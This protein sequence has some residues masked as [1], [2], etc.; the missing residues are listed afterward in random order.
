MSELNTAINKGLI[1]AGAG[2]VSLPEE[3]YNLGG[4][5][6]QF[7]GKNFG[8][9]SYGTPKM[10]GEK[11]LRLGNLFIGQYSPDYQY[12]R[13]D[14]PFF[15]SYQEAIEGAKNI[16]AP[17]FKDMRNYQAGD[18]IADLPSVLD[19]DLSGLSKV[20]EK[21]VEM[22]TGGALFTGFRKV[23]TFLA[24]GSSATGQALESSGV[25][26]EGNGWKIGLA[27]DIIGNVGFGAIKP[28]DAQRLKNILID[29]EKNGQTEQ[30]KQL[31]KF[32]KDNG[33]NITVPEAVSSVTGNKSILQLADNVVA[34]EGGAAVISNFTK[35]RFPQITEANRKWMNENFSFLNVDDIDPKII[36]N[37]FVNSLVEAQDNITKKINEKARNLKAGG[38][39]EFDLSNANI[40][41]TTQYM[42]NLFKRLTTGDLLDA[43]IIK[44]NILN[45][46]QSA[47][48]TDLSITNLKKIYDE[49]KDVTRN[50][51][52]E[53]SNQEA[54][55]L[56]KEL[57][58]IKQILDQNEYFARASEFTKRANTVLQGKFDALSIG[59]QVTKSNQ[60]AL[61]RS[62]N[63]IRSVL[64]DENVT[65]KNI[66]NLYTELNKIDATLFPEVSGM[67]LQK[68]FMKIATKGDDPNIGFKFYN[69]MM[70]P[71]NVSL[72]EEII[73]GSAIAQ[74]KD[75][76]KVWQGFTQLMNV[77]K[78]TGSAAKP[79]SQTASRQEFKENLKRLNIPLE[80]FEVTKP[81]S[82]VEGIKN[83]LY[84]QRATELANAFVSDDG[85]ESLIKIANASSFDQIV[86]NNKAILGFLNQEN[87][88]GQEELNEQK[89]INLEQYE[90]SGVL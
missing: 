11:G 37:K 29:L 7:M 10:E 4:L 63:T 27:L 66:K 8:T 23:P 19:A 85:L 47:N 80:N 40:E 26:S 56:D 54:F 75:P 73:K 44:D 78:A 46:L 68:N 1:Q 64:F 58:L 36:T 32:A 39:K 50:L 88:E 20:V 43:K 15:P 30:V 90:K 86:D 38:W 53:G 55:A 6:D 87:V 72:T 2:F 81:M 42:Q 51:R 65:S 67:L 9:I 21:G 79:G 84:N 48:R 22:G 89:I 74:G 60:A 45:K 62:M 35:N 70:S 25:V 77:Y 33:I 14:I 49:G 59:G 34:T 57:N 83:N 31:L 3:A 82:F 17:A 5:F 18:N 71:K 41:L 13:T 16:N 12:Q 24:G 69:S 76:N 61:D 28:N 52:K